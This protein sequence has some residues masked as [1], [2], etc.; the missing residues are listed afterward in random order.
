MSAE[1][2]RVI[3]RAIILTPDRR[4]VLVTSQAG[5]SLVLPGGAVDEGERLPQAAARET[6][7]ECGLKVTI[8]HAIWLREF[9]GLKRRRSNLE[10]YFLAQPVPGVTPPDR[11]EHAD[12]DKPGLVRK[13]GLYSRGALESMD[14]PV[15]PAEL[16][17]AF[18]LGLEDG[19]GDVYLGWFEG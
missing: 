11:W 17:E 6:Q 9:Y 12:P 10:V 13:A 2:F 15:Y 3:A 18:W 19:F 16:R 4:I 14:M 7:E 1:S 5:N 8:G